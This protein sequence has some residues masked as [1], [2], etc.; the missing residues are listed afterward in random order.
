MAKV[1]GNENV[2]I[3]F[4]HILREWGR[5]AC[6]SSHL[7]THL[8]EVAAYLSMGVFPIRRN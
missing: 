4:A 1:T 2:K 8:A 3:V 6:H 7:A 5:A